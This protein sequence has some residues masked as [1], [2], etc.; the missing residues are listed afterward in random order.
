MWVSNLFWRQILFVWKQ[1]L[2]MELLE[3]LVTLGVCPFREMCYDYFRD[4]VLSLGEC[5]G[6]CF[7]SSGIS[8]FARNDL[9]FFSRIVDVE[10]LVDKITSSLGA[11]FLGCALVILVPIMN[12][13]WN[14]LSVEINSLLRLGGV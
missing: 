14:H 10:Q 4:V 3:E 5:F 6:S 12:G 1:N 9:V 13:L 11:G 2:V 8:R 7:A